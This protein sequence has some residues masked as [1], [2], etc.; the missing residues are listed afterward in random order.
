MTIPVGTTVWLIIGSPAMTVKART[1]RDTYYCTWF[2]GAEYNEY[3]FSDDQLTTTEPVK[4]K[5]VEKS[6][7]VPSSIFSRFRSRQQGVNVHAS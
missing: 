5:Q 1:K 3:E 2:V 7:S 4:R 6:K